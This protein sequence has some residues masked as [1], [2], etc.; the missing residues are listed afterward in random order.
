ME[1]R[2]DAKIVG[3]TRAEG[4]RGQSKKWWQVINF[5]NQGEVTTKKMEFDIDLDEIPD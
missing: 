2:G 1:M 3:E 5:D 4:A